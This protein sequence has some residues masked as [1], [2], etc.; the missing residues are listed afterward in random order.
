VILLI[1]S[2]IVHYREMRNAPPP[3]AFDYPRI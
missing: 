1:W 2:R 3:I